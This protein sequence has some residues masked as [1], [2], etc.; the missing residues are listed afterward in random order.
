MKYMPRSI[1]EKARQK[2]GPHADGIVGST[3]AKPTDQ[4]S[5]QL[6]Q[7]LIQQTT[8]SQNPSS[9]SPS[10]QTSDIHSVQST[11]LKANQYPKGK[12]KQ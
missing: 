4:L 3:Q 8:A 11:N 10:T 9:V 7:L 5:N 2:S 6:Q 12:K 1:L